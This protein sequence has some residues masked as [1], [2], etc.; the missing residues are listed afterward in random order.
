M[1]RFMINGKLYT[2]KQLQSGIRRAVQSKTPHQ[3]LRILDDVPPEGDPDPVL[4]EVVNVVRDDPLA[5]QMLQQK[6]NRGL[7]GF[8]ELDAYLQLAEILVDLYARF[9]TRRKKRE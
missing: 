6:L 7:Q 9:R 1:K 8:G 3:L 4:T 2:E 5:E